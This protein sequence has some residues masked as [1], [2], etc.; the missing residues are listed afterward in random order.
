MKSL[1]KQ[2][3]KH[4]KN[5]PGRPDENDTPSSNLLVLCWWWCVGVAKMESR[6][7]RQLILHKTAEGLVCGILFFSNTNRRDRPRMGEGG[8]VLQRISEE[9]T[10]IERYI[11]EKRTYL[12]TPSHRIGY[13]DVLNFHPILVRGL[14]ATVTRKK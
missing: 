12:V 11:S 14:R 1:I 5:H 8:R 10:N 9:H 4:D 2:T 3:K 7:C 13:R 6:L